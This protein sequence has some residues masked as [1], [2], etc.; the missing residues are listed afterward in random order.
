MD[1]EIKESGSDDTP[2]TFPVSFTRKTIEKDDKGN[3][4]IVLD[5]REVVFNHPS[6]GQIAVIARAARKAERGGG[7]NIVE[8][9]GLILDVMDK[10]VV[11]P[12]NRN[13]LEEGLI[14]TSLKLDDFLGVL[15]GIN[16][17]KDDSKPAGPARVA[18][19]GRR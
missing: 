19:S 14:D 17:K 18:R 15:D 10:M 2:E 4:K 8:A 5:K 9:V 7:A 3:D 13:W 11:D 12:D 1:E 16:A 6:E